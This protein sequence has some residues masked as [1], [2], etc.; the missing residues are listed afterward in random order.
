MEDQ[1]FPDDNCELFNNDNVFAGSSYSNSQSF[2]QFEDENHDVDINQFD[3]QSQIYGKIIENDE[4]LDSD[5][6][7]IGFSNQCELNGSNQSELTRN[8]QSKL[9]DSNILQDQFE[10]QDLND[11]NSNNQVKTINNSNLDD[12][13]DDQLNDED[14]TGDSKNKELKKYLNFL[15][16]EEVLSKFAVFLYRRA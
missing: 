11:F 13:L 16:L 9:N 12:Q 8:N 15:S 1:I 6:E 14:V 4:I 2:N 5:N 7:I 10:E 3:N